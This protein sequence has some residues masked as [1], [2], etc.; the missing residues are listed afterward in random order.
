MSCGV[1]IKVVKHSGMQ[2]GKLTSHRIDLYGIHQPDGLL[3]YKH[4]NSE[5]QQ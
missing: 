4:L 1:E 3:Q 2:G 5:T